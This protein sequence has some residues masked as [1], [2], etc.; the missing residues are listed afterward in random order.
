MTVEQI[1]TEFGRERLDPIKDFGMAAGA[2][3]LDIAAGG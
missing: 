2:E 3:L 1:L